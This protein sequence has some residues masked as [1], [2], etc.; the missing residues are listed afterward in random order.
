MKIITTIGTS[1]LANANISYSSELDRRAY[2]ATLFEDEAVPSL[3]Q[4]QIKELIPKLVRY[5]KHE[6]QT[7]SAET[8][9]IAE[10]RQ[11]LHLNNDN[12]S[13]CFICTETLLARIVAE[14]LRL[15]LVDVKMEIIVVKGLVSDKIR[16][17]QEGLP[18]LKEIINKLTNTDCVFNLTGGYR[19]L[20]AYMTLWANEKNIPTYMI[21]SEEQAPKYEIIKIQN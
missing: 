9:S 16:F 14:A 10:I 3:I 5:I 4:R 18:H 21:L 7:A 17:E 12:I 8:T 1:L 6:G 19:A 11:T 2:D 20:M 13:I 15:A